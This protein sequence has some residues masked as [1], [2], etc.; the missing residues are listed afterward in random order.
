MSEPCSCYDLHGFSPD[1]TCLVHQPK[2]VV[3]ERRWPFKPPLQRPWALVRTLDG[4]P[5]G[6]YKNE[7]EALQVLA[8]MPR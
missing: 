7:R 2:Y 6:F 5:V 4:K 8:A 1:P 3:K